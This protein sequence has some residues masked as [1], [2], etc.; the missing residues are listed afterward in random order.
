MAARSEETQWAIKG[1]QMENKPVRPLTAAEQQLL[2]NVLLE[3]LAAQI[4]RFTAGE[5]SSVPAEKAQEL[6]ASLCMTLDIQNP[7]RAR[8]LLHGDAGAALAAGQKH[9]QYRWALCRQLWQ[10]AADTAPVWQNLALRET[11]ES[12]GQSVTAKAA[13]HVQFFAHELPCSIDYPLCDPVPETLQGAEYLA[14]YLKRLCEENALLAAVN[15]A[16]ARRMALA[17]CPDYAKLLVNLCEPTAVQLL[18]KSLLGHPL[19]PLE[20]DTAQRHA[21]GRIAC[22]LPTGQLRQELAAAARRAATQLNVPER[23]L[24]ATAQSLAVR[25]PIAARNNSLE[26]LF[27]SRAIEVK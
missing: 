1:E 26:N 12:I 6:M 9:L 13:Y 14:E 21:V 10:R 27:Y 11:L 3:L 8:Q 24:L 2:Q 5:R 19:Y 23:P 20:L 4:V 16:A 15:Q 22:A 7:A 17:S 25:L 18:G